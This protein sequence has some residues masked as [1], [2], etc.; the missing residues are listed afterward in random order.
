MTR[1]PPAWAALGPFQATPTRAP[2]AE[3]RHF[4]ISCVCP[5][6]F[7]LMVICEPPQVCR[8]L[9]CQLPGGKAR[10]QIARKPDPRHRGIA[11]IVGV[12]S[13]PKCIIHTLEIL[14]NGAV[15][16]GGHC[17]LPGAN[18]VSYF[19]QLTDGFSL[20]HFLYPAR[21]LLALAILGGGMAALIRNWLPDISMRFKSHREAIIRTDEDF[22]ADNPILSE[23][24]RYAPQAR[25]VVT[26]LPIYA[27]RANLLVPPEL[28]VFTRKRMETGFLTE[29]QVIN[30]IEA[31]QPEQIL[32]GRFRYD[33]L[34]DYVTERFEPVAE[35]EG[36]RLYVR[37]GLRRPGN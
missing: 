33:R 4:E 1:R 17:C 21:Y 31:Y 23:M 8:Q 29:A 12:A 2:K 10:R 35:K 26:D 11:A 28:A 36:A 20:N 18:P 5:L 7:T 22:L 34:D 13:S 19:Q 24:T 14:G 3:G 25:W 15:I 27:F 6:P 32:L 9:G 37:E 16:A 30:V